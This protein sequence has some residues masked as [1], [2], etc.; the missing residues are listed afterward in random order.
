METKD[1]IKQRRKELGLS[2]AQ[3]AEQT[4]YDSKHSITK[5]ETGVIQV[6]LKKLPMFAKALKCSVAYLLDLDKEERREYNLDANLAYNDVQLLSKFD[7]LSNSNKDIIL[8]LID[9]LTD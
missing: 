2:Q 4:G 3:L 8:K 5:I 9:A 6:P 7:K 1:I